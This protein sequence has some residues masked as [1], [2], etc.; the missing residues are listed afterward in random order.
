MGEKYPPSPYG[1]PLD[2]TTNAY[3]A[4]I[5]KKWFTPEEFGL[6]LA[7]I[8]PSSFDDSFKANAEMYAKAGWAIRLIEEEVKA[9]EETGED[10]EDVPF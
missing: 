2:K 7:D 6:L 8:D 1:K 4:F 10:Y 9:V 5:A 3:K